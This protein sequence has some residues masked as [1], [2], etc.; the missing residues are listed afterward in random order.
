MIFKKLCAAVAAL[1]MTTAVFSGTVSATITPIGQICKDPYSIKDGESVDVYFKF[2]DNVFD[3]YV[4]EAQKD[5]EYCINYD[6]HD[7]QT[8]D[9]GLTISQIRPGYS[10]TLCYGNLDFSLLVYLRA[11][12]RISI[13]IGA[14]AGPKSGL[15][16][17]SLSISYSKI[18]VSFKSI[19]LKRISS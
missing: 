5:G 11:G 19:A 17:G 16:D 18:T 10:R 9:L 3:A 15:I 12:S 8:C 1:V 4:F 6:Y 7:S 13:S 14:G 2:E